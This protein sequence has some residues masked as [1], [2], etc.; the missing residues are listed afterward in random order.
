[1]KALLKLTTLAIIC[2][3]LAAGQVMADEEKAE[4]KEVKF[5][6]NAHC[7]GCV[8]KIEGKLNDVDGVESS[9]L[10]MASKVV[11]VKYDASETNAKELRETIK[12]AG[13]DATVEKSCG[14]NKGCCKSK[15]NRHPDKC[16]TDTKTTD[17]SKDKLK[18][19]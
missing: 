9:K 11:T 14:S 4:L 10:D 17:A 19:S 2:L 13:Y 7:G 5:K 16:K 1:M 6:T 15:A 8:S 18:K 12:N 3:V